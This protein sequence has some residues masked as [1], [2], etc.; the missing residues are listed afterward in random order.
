MGA[1]NANSIFSR[2]Q[3]LQRLPS[4]KWY[5][6][7]TSDIHKAQRIKQNKTKLNAY[8]IYTSR[9]LPLHPTLGENA[10]LNLFTT[11]CFPMPLLHAN[12]ITCV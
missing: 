5:Y 9:L 1:H 2:L 12:C 3:E 6:S 7:C 8:G 11:A 10:I 4:P